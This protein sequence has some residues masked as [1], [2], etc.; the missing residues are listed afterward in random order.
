MLGRIIGVEGVVRLLVALASVLSGAATWAQEAKQPATAAATASWK[1]GTAKVKITPE[2][3]MWM[4]GYGGRDH[5]AEGTTSDLW[6]KVLILEDSQSRRLALITLD[7]V[8][9]DRE[10]TLGITRRLEQQHQL[11]REQIAICTS[12]THCGPVVGYN[13]RPMHYERVAPEQQAKIRDYAKR[14]EELVVK[15][16]GEAMGTLAPAQVHWGSGRSTFAVNRRTNREAEVPQVRAVGKLNGPVDHDVPVLAV[17]DPE[18]K[19]RTVVFGYACHA[20]VLGFYQWCADYPGFAQTE[21]ER[22]HPETVAMF[23]AGCG[24]DQ[25]PLPRRTVELAQDYGRRLAL[26]VEDVLS[27]PMTPVAASAEAS[28]LEVALPLDKLPTRETIEKEAESKD[29]F[30]AARAKMFLREMDAGKTLSPTYPYPI[31]QWKLG[32]DIQWI[33]LGGEV[34]VDYAV[35]L[36]REHRGTKTWVA[37]YANDVMAY[38]PSR[39]VLTEGGY[40]GAG[41]MVYYGLPTAWAPEVEQVIVDAIAK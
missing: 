29:S 28:Y 37:G 39:R 8:G 33:F 7:L 31:G 12:H 19:L 35:R 20:T 13:L 21:L 25:N 38:I 15:T 34:V 6:A 32:D 27:A 14:L 30:L 26:A 22:L 1:A 40:E 36:K 10:T 3:P 24:A 18:G 9:I 5:V 4:A 16:V 41:A 11:K 23:W 17:R 2:S